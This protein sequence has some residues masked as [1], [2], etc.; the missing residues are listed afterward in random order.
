MS[1]RARIGLTV[2]EIDTP[3]DRLELEAEFEGTP[4]AELFR[5]W[6]APELLTQ[7]WPREAEVEAQKG[8]SYHLSWPNMEWHLRGTYQTFS[9]GNL[10]VFTWRWDHEP[11]TPTRIVTLDFQPLEGES[12]TYLHLTHGYYREHLPKDMEEKQGHLEGWH[13]FL[14]RLQEITQVKTEEG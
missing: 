3:R 11:H 8:G 2:R 5:Y 12:G 7:W 6:T 4:A 1:A 9:P 14:G 10:L 13:Y